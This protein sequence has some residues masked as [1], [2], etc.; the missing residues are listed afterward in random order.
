MKRAMHHQDNTENLKTDVSHVKFQEQE[1]LAFD[2]NILS[3]G[4][5]MDKLIQQLSEG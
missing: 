1:I 5:S 2:Q 3:I 4:S